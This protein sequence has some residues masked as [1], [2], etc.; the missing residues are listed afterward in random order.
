M[1]EEAPS[2]VPPM[3]STSDSEEDQTPTKGKKSNV[4]KRK[5]TKTK[6]K[7]AKFTKTKVKE[8][9]VSDGNSS[10]SE[11][12]QPNISSQALKTSVSKGNL[13]DSNDDI[14]NS[15]TK[16]RAILSSSDTDSSGSDVVQPGQHSNLKRRQQSADAESPQPSS[17][18]ESIKAQRRG[19]KRK[20]H[21]FDESS[22]A[23]NANT[24]SQ[25]EITSDGTDEENE[26]Q[27]DED[28]SGRE[29]NT[30]SSVR[31]KISSHGHNFH[32]PRAELMERKR[33]KK[34]KLFSKLIQTRRR[35]NSSGNL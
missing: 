28:D 3:K 34:R 25:V 21:M 14:V 30:R 35:R 19:V 9:K 13:S 29:V 27:D 1:A 4:A 2:R 32:S 26:E 5:F 17:N 16:I 31:N 15:S 12:E 20:L 11:D 33:D 8:A 10:S 23:S 18:D 7:G 24:D 22:E 6:V